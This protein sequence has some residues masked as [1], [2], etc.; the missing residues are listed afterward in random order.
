MK[1]G[2]RLAINNL[3]QLYA[4]EVICADRGFKHTFESPKNDK[5]SLFRHR[6]LAYDH[7]ILTP[8]KSKG[9]PLVQKL[10]AAS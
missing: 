7:L 3:G 2:R 5:L 4:N 8:P 10:Q 1:V 9:Q 6:E